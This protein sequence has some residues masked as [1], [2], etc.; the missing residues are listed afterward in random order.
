VAP[1]DAATRMGISDT[2]GKLRADGYAVELGVTARDELGK[3]LP[4]DRLA[5]VLHDPAQ[6]SLTVTGVADLSNLADGVVI[7]LPLLP[8][9]S[10]ADMTA[11]IALL[12]AALPSDRKPSL[13]APPSSKQ[14][15]DL[16]GGSAVNL[17]ALRSSINRVYSMTLDLHCCDGM[18]GPTTDTDWIGDVVKL[19]T[20]QLGRST[21]QFALPLYGSSFSPKA[22]RAVT[23]L[24]AVGLASEQQLQIL[25]TDDGDLHYSYVD[26]QQVRHDVWFDDG[27][28]LLEK[29]SQVDALL[30]PDVGV[31]LYGLG[32]ED[33]A[34]WSLL[35]DHMK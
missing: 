2:V 1:G 26:G 16:P 33:P 19:A 13:F 25:R 34:V 28:S 9:T 3:D 7:A 22:L 17:M 4:A 10:E 27:R 18:P 35:K 32:G 6:R 30:M 20:Q 21:V 31:L 24:E 5:A 11:W 14:P 23:F 12:A 8:S 29:L 15:S